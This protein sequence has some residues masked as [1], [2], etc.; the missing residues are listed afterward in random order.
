MWGPRQTWAWPP[1]RASQSP[2]RQDSPP[3][4]EHPW[5]WRRSMTGWGGARGGLGQTGSPAS[6]DFPAD[7]HGCLPAVPSPGSAS[8]SPNPAGGL[9]P[10]V[11]L[12]ETLRRGRLSP[13]LKASKPANGGWG[14]G[15]SSVSLTL[16]PVPS[17]TLGRRT[18][19]RRATPGSPLC[20]ALPVGNGRGRRGA[21]LSSGVRS[22]V[23]DHPPPGLQGGS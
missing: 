3:G 19:R 14:Q 2:R 11:S 21:R 13:H 9:L 22:P 16:E 10:S 4:W 15:P 17:G 20:P 18:P 12:M 7:M 6:E 23:R 1:R 5:S 8:E